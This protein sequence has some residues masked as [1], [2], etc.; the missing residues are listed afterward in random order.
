[1]T[2]GLADEVNAAITDGYPATYDQRD[3]DG[4]SAHYLSM[5]CPYTPLSA[6]LIYADPLFFR[7]AEALLGDPVI[8]DGTTT[9]ASASK[10]SSSPHTSTHVRGYLG[11]QSRC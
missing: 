8:P 4:I 9:T 7:A 3:T 2:K 11:G 6:S 1:V 5:A 10:V